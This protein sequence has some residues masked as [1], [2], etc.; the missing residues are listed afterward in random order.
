[1]PNLT[2]WLKLD[3]NPASAADRRLATRFLNYWE[4]LRGD[5]RLPSPTDLNF[6][7]IS[8]FIPHTF[9][10]DLS[11]GA[12][13]PTFRFVGKD[14]ARDCDGDFANRRMSE[15]PPLSLLAQT[16]RHFA[17]VVAHGEPVVVSDRFIAAW[18]RE[19]LFRAVMLPFSRTGHRTDCIIGA[20]NSKSVP[21]DDAER[22]ARQGMPAAAKGVGSTPPSAEP[23]GTTQ[24]R[25]PEPCAPAATERRGVSDLGAAVE[26]AV[27]AAEPASMP[28]EKALRAEHREGAAKT[29]GAAPGQTIVVGSA[30]GGT[31]KSTTAMHLIVSLLYEGRKVGIIDLDRS[32]QTL[33]RYI[34]NRRA[35]SNRRG[36]SLPMPEQVAVPDSALD[37]AGLEI[38]LGNLLG[39]CDHVVIDT[40]GSDTALSRRAHAW[41]DKVI[42]PIND[43]FLDLDTLASVDA[44]TGEVVTRGHYAEIVLQAREQKADMTGGM[45]NWI[46]IRNR[47]SQ[48][49]APNKQKMADT[50]EMLATSLDFRNE[51]GLGERMI[52]RELFLLGL[53]LLDLRRY[54]TGIALTLSHIAARQELRTL[55]KQIHLHSKAVST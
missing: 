2:S 12:E 50:L 24:R 16:V 8:E 18:N 41:A 32:Q 54:D 4:R 47:L 3:S 31:G 13:D 23:Q 10:I 27:A 52:Y 33:S 45:F 49:G 22:R 1:M 7:D 36:L 6:D 53:T 11:T 15:L 38:E 29:V 19:V 34:E 48:L 55:L 5:Q 28:E 30:M 40:P 25:G 17:E 43:S 35:L 9:N 42:T 39:R 37:A 20:V 44:D 21:I 26:T 14:L 51:S 46:V